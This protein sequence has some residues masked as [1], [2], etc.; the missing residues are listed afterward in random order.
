MK[1]LLTSLLSSKKFVVSMAGVITGLLVKAGLPETTA[2][3]LV[4]L[5]LPFVGYVVAQGIGGDR[6]DAQREAFAQA[7]IDRKEDREQQ[8]ADEARR[9]AQYQAGR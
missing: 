2:A 3:E 1:K 7:A 8:L 4:T 9:E 5:I 6:K